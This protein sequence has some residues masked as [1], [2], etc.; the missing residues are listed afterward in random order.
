MASTD[1]PQRGEIW[2]ASLGAA[3]SGEPGKTR[4]VAVVSPAELLGDSDRE[5]VVVVPLSAT[6]NQ[7]PL[8]PAVAKTGGL[9]RESV[10]VTRAIRGVSRSRLVERIG[11]LAPAESKA[12]GE[13]LKHTL[14]LR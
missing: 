1:R 3:R 2:L 8:R 4:P 10:A 6:V 7:S 12:L 11:K 13:A 9:E 5:L 14:L